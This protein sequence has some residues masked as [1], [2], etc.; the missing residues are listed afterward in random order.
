MNYTGLL[1][2]LSTFLT[3][4]QDNADFIAI[5]PNIINDAEGRIYKDIP[6]IGIRD[7]DTS[8]KFVAG[9]REVSIPDRMIFTEQVSFVDS[10]QNKTL[11]ER[12]LDWINMCYPNRATTGTPLFWARFTDE[13][14]VVA[15]TPS[16]IKDLEFTGLIRP[17]PISVSN[18][19]TY[20]SDNYPELLQAATMVYGCA[21]Q[22]EWSAMASDPQM[23]TS[24]ESTYQSRLKSAAE[25]EARKRG[26]GR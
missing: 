19:N 5:L 25:E 17:E 8:K 3:V 11:S 6:L 23:A 12:S 16:A 18:A 22:R 20:L 7:T 14:I 15:P 13:I 21:Y 1:T 26:I 9:N 10:G 2:F 24:W 4:P